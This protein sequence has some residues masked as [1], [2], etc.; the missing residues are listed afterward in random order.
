MTKEIRIQSHADDSVTLT[1]GSIEARITGDG[2]KDANNAA[3]VL[4]AYIAG[5]YELADLRLRLSGMRSIVQDVERSL[6]AAEYHMRE[7]VQY[8]ASQSESP[9]GAGQHKRSDP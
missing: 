9:A 4:G 5:T 1:V 3:H 6:H 7:L 8:A 2:W